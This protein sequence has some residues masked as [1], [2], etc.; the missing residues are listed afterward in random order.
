ML[1]M[2]SILLPSE[3][4]QNI[5]PVTIAVKRSLCV[6]CHWAKSW[7]WA[8]RPDI[9]TTNVAF[10]MRKMSH[11]GDWT[12]ASQ[13]VNGGAPMKD[14][15]NIVCMIGR[16]ATIIVGAFV[17]FMSK[18][19]VRIGSIAFVVEWSIGSSGPWSSKI[20]SGKGQSVNIDYLSSADFAVVNLFAL[21]V[22]GAIAIVVVE[23]SFAVA[24]SINVS[25]APTEETMK[26]D[27]H[28][29][30]VCGL[31]CASFKNLYGEHGRNN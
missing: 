23:M 5:M 15:G 6:V 28:F 2:V 7:I 24:V 20:F 8:W 3:V 31:A 17:H 22:D 10:R 27:S 13:Q 25:C 11:D 26:D 29:F 18:I 21:H 16:I 1:V 30:V 14:G 19:S 4:L 12:M 9:S